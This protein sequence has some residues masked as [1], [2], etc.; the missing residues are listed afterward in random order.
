[1]AALTSNKPNAKFLDPEHINKSRDKPL[2]TFLMNVNL[3]QMKQ[4]NV[5][6]KESFPLVE[7]KYGLSKKIKSVLIAQLT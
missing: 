2:K 6:Y 3:N 5:K 7:S 4:P 1:M